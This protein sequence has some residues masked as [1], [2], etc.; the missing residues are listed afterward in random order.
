MLTLLLVLLLKAGTMALTVLAALLK[1]LQLQLL[2]VAES[3]HLLSL[4]LSALVSGR[5]LG[6]LLLLLSTSSAL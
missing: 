5:S 2:P 4:L 6:L 1:L 3:A